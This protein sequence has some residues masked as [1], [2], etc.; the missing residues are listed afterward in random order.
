MLHLLV[1]EPGDAPEVSSSE[2]APGLTLPQCES[3]QSIIFF[4]TPYQRAFEFE[5]AVERQLVPGSG[6]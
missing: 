5:L 3:S 2:N 4:S 1:K 6:G